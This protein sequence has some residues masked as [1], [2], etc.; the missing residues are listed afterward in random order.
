[1][2]LKQAKETG[3]RTLLE[4]NSRIQRHSDK[5]SMKDKGSSDYNGGS[6]EAEA[7]AERQEQ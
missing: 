6:K 2:T 4:C 1:M 7:E 5:S 3:E